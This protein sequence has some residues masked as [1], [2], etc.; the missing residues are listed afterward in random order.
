MTRGNGTPLLA[1]NPTPSPRLSKTSKI[2]D[3][4]K[5]YVTLAAGT[6]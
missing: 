5:S 3:S 4:Q 2:E 6:V 1:E